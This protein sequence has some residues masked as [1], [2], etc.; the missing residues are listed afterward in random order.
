[1]ESILT[2]IKKP[3]G[4]AAEYTHFDADIIMHINTVFLSLNQIG[5]GPSDPASISSV[6]DTWTG[7]FGDMKN[8]E[9][10]KTYTYLKVRM[11]FDPPASSTVLE[12]MNRQASELEW[13]L[14]VQ[15]ESTK[16]G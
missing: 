10:I 11:V 15:A 13:R 4:I 5:V 12:A 8:I 14:H 16:E 9:A 3:L 1:M 2:S 6:M 7:V